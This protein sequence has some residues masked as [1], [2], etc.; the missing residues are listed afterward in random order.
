MWLKNCIEERG[1]V[2]LY[3]LSP[4]M[5]FASIE[6]LIFWRLFRLCTGLHE[7]HFSVRLVLLDLA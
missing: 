7:V 6:C 2:F 5:H 4:S 3:F 1:C